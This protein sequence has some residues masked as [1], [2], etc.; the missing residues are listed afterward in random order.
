MMDM[1]QGEKRTK[2]V[3]RMLI[4]WRLWV[5]YNEYYGGKKE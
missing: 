1:L 4:D 3:M 5:K 2:G